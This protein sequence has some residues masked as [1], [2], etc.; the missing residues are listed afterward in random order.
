MKKQRCEASK[1]K[2]EVPVSRGTDGERHRLQ[3]GHSQKQVEKEI[4]CYH[5]FPGSELS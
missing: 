5:N 1:L 3:E 4:H 2:Q